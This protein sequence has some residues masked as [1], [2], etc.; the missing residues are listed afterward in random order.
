MTEYVKV[1]ISPQFIRHIVILIMNG[2]EA[3]L[4][5]RRTPMGTVERLTVVEIT[6]VSFAEARKTF[7]VIKMALGGISY[8]IIDADRILR[9]NDL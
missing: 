1:S 4:N 7:F 6:F 5:L 3:G 8:S 9:T 2:R